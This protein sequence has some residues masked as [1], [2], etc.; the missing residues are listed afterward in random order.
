MKKQILLIFTMLLTLFIVVGW[1]NVLKPSKTSQVFEPAKF[2]SIVLSGSLPGSPKEKYAVYMLQNFFEGNFGHKL[3]VLAKN[4]KYDGNAFV[5]M[6][7]VSDLGEEGYQI[8]TSPKGDI[9]LTGGKR[10]GVINAVVALLEEDFGCRW[11]AKGDKAVMPG[12]I[13]DLSFSPRSFTPFM[14][15]RTILCFEVF[16]ADYEIKNRLNMSWQSRIPQALGGSWNF[17]HNL[18]AHTLNTLL[19]GKLFSTHPEYFPMIN[20]KRQKINPVAPFQICMTNPEVENIVVKNL[21]KTIAANPNCEVFSVSMNDNVNGFCQ[22]SKCSDMEKKYGSKSGVLIDFVNRVAQ[23]IA[24]KYPNVK[25]ETLAYLDARKAP[26]SQIHPA[27][28]VLVRFCGNSLVPYPVKHKNHID[29]QLENWKK[30][31][32]ELLIWD[33]ITDHNDDLSMMVNLWQIN[34]NL[35]YY[36]AQKA[37]GV[38][39]QSS[40]Q[41]PGGADMVMKSWIFAKRMWNPGWKLR[42]LMKDFIYGYYGAAAPAVWKYYKLQYQQFLKYQ[43]YNPNRNPKYLRTVAGFD[44]VVPAQK[45]L[46]KA[47]RI[48][49]GDKNLTKKLDRIDLNLTYWRLCAGPRNEADIENFKKDIKKFWKLASIFKVTH[50]REGHHVGQKELWKLKIECR[51]GDALYR[52]PL[53]PEAL[54]FCPHNVHLWQAGASTAHRVKEGNRIIMEQDGRKPTWSMQWDIRSFPFIPKRRYR[55]VAKVRAQDADKAQKNQGLIRVAAYDSKRKYSPPAITFTGKD[56]MSGNWTIKKSEP[57]ELNESMVVYVS[58][59]AN[60]TIKKLQVDS[61]QMVPE[62]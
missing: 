61:I 33:Y 52:K 53:H 49:A 5:F 20:G 62:D 38:M 28:N 11:Y 17:P 19:P 59:I 14:L 23:R 27:P 54:L 3:N 15:D 56:L 1:R 41:S 24:R 57:F 32:T 35:N 30:I 45:I 21:L 43:K 26:N 2:T 50:F 13:K 4:S 40:Y 42:D 47:F 8:S 44:F 6:P 29:K 55:I 25:I 22:C 31:G 37:R 10:R 58:P 36:F 16:D 48:A 60:K 34:R 18:M 51:I 9:I 39:M 7:F 12:G 46:R